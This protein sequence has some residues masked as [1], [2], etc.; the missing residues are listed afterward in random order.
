MLF[1]SPDTPSQRNARR[2][3]SVN[4][5]GYITLRDV[6]IEEIFPLAPPILSEVLMEITKETKGPVDIRDR[7]LSLIV[8]LKLNGN[9]NVPAGSTFTFGDS[10]SFEPVEK[11]LD[12]PLISGTPQCFTI[13]PRKRFRQ[14]EQI[15]E[16][17]PVVLTIGNEKF[18]I[19]PFIEISANWFHDGGNA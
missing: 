12:D 3:E 2:M 4:P 18:L 17:F 9:N 10:V 16:S 13:R 1:V 6:R 8:T 7:T 11:I 14:I 15:P 19:E 5:R